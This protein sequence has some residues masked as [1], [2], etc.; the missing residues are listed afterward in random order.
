MFVI[1]AFSG[2]LVEVLRRSEH[3]AALVD[4]SSEDRSLYGDPVRL[5]LW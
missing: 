4:A 3:A 5:N 2:Y 1:A